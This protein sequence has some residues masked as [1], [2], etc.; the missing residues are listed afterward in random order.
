MPNDTTFELTIEQSLPAEA[1]T[2]ICREFI[3]IFL[4][5]GIRTCL[6]EAHSILHPELHCALQDDRPRSCILCGAGL[7]KTEGLSAL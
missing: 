4:T 6:C 5:P 2:I 7:K 1:K 3:K